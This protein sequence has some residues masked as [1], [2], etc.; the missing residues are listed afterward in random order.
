MVIKIG[1]KTDI[2]NKLSQGGMLHM[3]LKDSMCSWINSG[4][5]RTHR[6]K[7]QPKSWNDIFGYCRT[8]PR[9]A[10]VP[11]RDRGRMLL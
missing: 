8:V 7:S 5:A 4:F 2:E 3:S 1:W 6:I 10:L 9:A 11:G